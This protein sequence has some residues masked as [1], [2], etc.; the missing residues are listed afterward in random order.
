MPGLVLGR[1]FTWARRGTC[2]GVSVTCPELSKMLC[3]R[4]IC[5]S[6]RH[7]PA[8]AICGS[9]R[10]SGLHKAAQPVSGRAGTVCQLKP[11]SHR[12]P[13]APQCP[14]QHRLWEAGEVQG[15]AGFLPWGVR[16][17]PLASRGVTEDIQ[18]SQHLPSRPG[19]WHAEGAGGS[20]W[21]QRVHPKGTSSPKPIPPPLAKAGACCRVGALCHP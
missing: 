13:P 19:G 20:P 8:E 7:P 1:R 3:S 14:K 18:K 17:A 16:D 15:G 11:V 12:P 5:Q 4:S 9:E 6:L 21:F 2:A 10:E